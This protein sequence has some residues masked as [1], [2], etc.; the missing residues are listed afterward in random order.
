MTAHV[1]YDAFDPDS[2]ATLSGPMLSGLL[3]GELRFDGLV[4]TDALNMQGVLDA[5]GG[6]A[7]DAAI[8]ALNAGCNA[9][10]YPD[11]FMAIADALEAELRRSLS[12]RA[13]TESL[14]RV[15]DAAERVP[16]ASGG[17]CGAGSD[18]QWS[19]QVAVRSVTS[20]RDTVDLPRSFD[21][22]T[23]DDDLGGPFAP[24]P[25]NVFTAALHDEGFDVRESAVAHADRPVVIALYSDI[26]AWKGEPTVSPAARAAIA[27]ALA[28]RSDAVIAL[29]GH[30]R[31]A[32]HVPGRH[33][34]AA[35]GGEAVMQRAAAQWLAVA[36][37][38]AVKGGGH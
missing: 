15:R 18:A 27:A 24:P 1:V 9:I 8:R 13:V 36:S 34:F 20:L 7:R 23:L 25:R 38:R 37:G 11:D 35:W 4:V 10:L 32:E 29:F 26:R 16:G 5:A 17:D 12:E 6:D 21:L 28:V 19:L 31:L 30:P 2:P 33:L 14:E 3:R 22:V